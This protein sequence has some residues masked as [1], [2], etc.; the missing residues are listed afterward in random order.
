MTKLSSQTE[1]AKSINQKM[2]ISN[3]V[4]VFKSQVG[5]YLLRRTRGGN[6]GL[7]LEL[8]TTSNASAVSYNSKGS[9]SINQD[10]SLFDEALVRR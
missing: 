2:T 9:E 4:F 5:E 10:G 6:R 8:E 7:R 3:L 1:M